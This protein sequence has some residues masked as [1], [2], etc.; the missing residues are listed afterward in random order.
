M[1]EQEQNQPLQESISIT[2]PSGIIITMQSS[3]YDLP[4]LI[5]ESKELIKYFT[6]P[7]DKINRGNYLG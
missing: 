4:I 3:H 5:N 2:L 6:K 7:N 1:E